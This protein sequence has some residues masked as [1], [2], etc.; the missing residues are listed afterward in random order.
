MQWRHSLNEF[1]DNQGRLKLLHRWIS[2]TLQRYGLVIESLQ[3]IAGE[4]S[5][6]RYYRVRSTLHEKA[7]V[8]MDAAPWLEDNF[9][10]VAIAD[11]LASA[12][13]R[14]PAIY[15]WDKANGFLLLEDMGN[16]TLL[17]INLRMHKETSRPYYY[18]A[19]ETL[20]DMQLNAPTNNLATFSSEVMRNELDLF[21]DWYLGKHLK[22]QLTNNQQREI[23]SLFNLIIDKTLSIEQVFVHR[24][25]RP[26]N[27]VISGDGKEIAVLDFQ[28]AVKGPIT[29][30]LV[31]LLWDAFHC[32]DAQFTKQI[33]SYYWTTAVRKGL[34]VPS[35]LR[36]FDA[37]L[38]WTRLQRHV[39]VI[40]IFARLAL[41]DGKHKYLREIERFNNYIASS[42]TTKH[43]TQPLL[44]LL[45]SIKPN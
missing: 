16:E 9:A 39:R 13:I 1:A 18:Q 24:D 5:H 19:I 17:Q 44:K 21:T 33:V 14:V 12:N 27:L 42:T 30:D 25:F 34:P 28:D 41:R 29:Y 45:R 20:I 8:I 10:F 37:S 35:T 11:V 4:A 7:F 38:Y 23:S 22:I 6:R 26:G 32:W 2:F 36:A 3:F 15:E 43:G 40:G 31:S